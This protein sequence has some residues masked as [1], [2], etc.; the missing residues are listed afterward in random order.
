MKVDS[1]TTPPAPPSR[2]S[3]WQIALA[4]QIIFAVITLAALALL[5]PVDWQQYFRKVRMSGGQSNEGS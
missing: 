2:L 1:T 4:L 3:F 5:A